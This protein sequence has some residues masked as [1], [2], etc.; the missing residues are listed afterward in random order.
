MYMQLAAKR[1]GDIGI[2]V[3]CESRLNIDLLAG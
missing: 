1:V 3:P 2:S